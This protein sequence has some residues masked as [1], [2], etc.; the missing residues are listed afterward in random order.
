MK[1]RSRARTRAA[2]RGARVWTLP[3]DAMT[4]DA[5][6]RGV[7]LELWRRDVVQEEVFEDK[8]DVPEGEEEEGK[9]GEEEEGK[10]GEGG[11]ERR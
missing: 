1:T 3:I 2:R 6:L 4:R 8:E 10:E 9:E 11:G 7:T 5:F